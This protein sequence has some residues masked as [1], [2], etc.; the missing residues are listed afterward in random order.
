VKK[1]LF[2]ALTIALPI[3]AHAQTSCGA[4]SARSC[5]NVQT[6]TTSGS[7]I[8]IQNNAGL[9]PTFE[10][11]WTGSPSGITVTLQGCGL[12]GTCETLDT[13]SSSTNS[14]RAPTVS[15]VYA[16]Y[17]VTATWTGTATL[18]VSTI[19]TSARNQGGGSGGGVPSVN[20][21]TTATTIAAGGN[22]GVNTNGNTITVSTITISGV[23]FTPVSDTSIVAQWTT[24]TPAD[25]N[26][27]CGGV[28]ADD[29]GRQTAVT[30]THEVVF[31]GL[32]ATSSYPCHVTS[33]GISSSTQN[34]ETLSP[35]TRTPILL[36]ILGPVTSTSYTGD[37]LANFLSSDNFHYLGIDDSTSPG[38]SANMSL[39]KITN[40]STLAMSSVNSLSSYGAAGTTNGTDGPGGVALSYKQSS[41]FGMN[42]CLYLYTNRNLYSSGGTV[43]QTAYFGNVI[44]DNCNHGATL[45]NHQ[46][47][48]TFSATGSPDGPGVSMFPDSVNQAWCAF[49]RFG[50]D[51][52]TPGYL[53]PGNAIDG[54]N[55]YVYQNCTDGQWNNSSHLWMTRTLRADFAS[56]TPGNKTQWWCGPSSPAPSDFVNPGNW[57][58]SSSCRTSI[59]T[60]S[61]QVGTCDEVFVPGYNYYVLPI[62]Y[63]STT[64]TASSTVWN[65]QSG[66]TPAGPFTSFFIQTFSPQGWYCPTFL[67]RSIASNSGTSGVNATVLMTGN[68]QGTTYYHPSYASMTLDYAQVQ[69]SLP[70]PTASFGA[71]YVGLVNSP[72]TANGHMQ[73]FTVMEDAAYSGSLN[74]G[75][76]TS[77]GGGNFTVTNYVT[78]TVAAVT[79]PQTFTAPANFTAFATTSGEYPCFYAP[80]GNGVGKTT[81]GSTPGFY[82]TTT[83]YGSIPSGS[84]AYTGAGTPSAGSIDLSE[85]ISIP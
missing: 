48:A 51:D 23:V 46:A 39:L 30:T 5:Q 75:V 31:T 12:A 13:Y 3:A 2:L 28:P 36:G 59:Y 34:V 77:N 58:Y 9:V 83:S 80:T 57:S 81:S 67:H 14:L 33:A 85:T 78:V 1:L 45:N 22:T 50:P 42:G 35:A 44:A 52:G 53:T 76:C 72:F 61:G 64:G 43:P 79:T 62:W 10:Y 47:P 21:I 15:K 27:F 66:P 74:V 38:S 60:A 56:L 55:A 16:T 26:A 41:L 82:Y 19:I 63:Q 40:E 20:G 71:Q 8:T 68:Y 65:F 11:T 29:N 70:T 17:T 73:A 54:A 69:G 4:Q 18:T 25:S 49:V 37:I 84:V 6:I 32:I 7:S 24:D